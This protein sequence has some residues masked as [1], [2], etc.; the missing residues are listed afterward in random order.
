MSIF[1]WIFNGW[2]FPPLTKMVSSVYHFSSPVAPALIASCRWCSFI[3][4]QILNISFSF[5]LFFIFELQLLNPCLMAVGASES[6]LPCSVCCLHSSRERSL[7]TVKIKH[8]AANKEAAECVG[9]AEVLLCCFVHIHGSHSCYLMKFMFE[10]AH[11]VSLNVKCKYEHGVSVGVI[12]GFSVWKCFPACSTWSV[13]WLNFS[14]GPILVVLFICISNNN[15]EISWLTTEVR[16]E[17]W[18]LTL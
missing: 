2:F 13:F 17:V 10:S 16:E 4:E 8:S 15:S 18:V 5:L 12:V 11:D 14:C 9:S 7:L 3:T 1:T 6:S